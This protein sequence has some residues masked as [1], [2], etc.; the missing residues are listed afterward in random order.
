MT[1]ELSLATVLRHDRAV[2]AAGLAGLTAVGWAALG[3]Q[4]RAMPCAAMGM[5]MS[6]PDLG[7]WGVG[8]LWAL[9]AMWAIMMAA[10]MTPSVAPMVLVFADVNRRR[11]EVARPFVPTGV[12]L[13]G[14]LAAWTAFSALATLA[15]WGLHAAAWLSPM[16][17]LTHSLAGGIVLASAGLFQFTPLKRACLV[18]CRTPLSFLMTEWREGARGA[19]VMGW[20]HGSYCVG[21]CW[22]LMALLFVAGVMNLVWVAVIAGFVLAEKVAPARWHVSRLAGALLLG[23][24]IWIAT[25]ALR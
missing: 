18:H 20:R 9:F 2:V 5:A 21:C 14:Y 8:D 7:A 17:A 24:G 13:V 15:Q 1:E 22:L 19:L 25:G 4:A 23:W 10:M 11:R 3:Y 16:M 6:A 12:F